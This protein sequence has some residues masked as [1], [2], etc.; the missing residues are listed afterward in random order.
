MG[1]R[2]L[3]LE[4]VAQGPDKAMADLNG[5]V[6]KAASPRGELR[7]R[8]QNTQESEQELRKRE[9]AGE[10][11]TRR[12]AMGGVNICLPALMGQRPMG[13]QSVAREPDKV[14][15]DLDGEA[16]KATPPRGEL[17]LRE[18]DLR[19][20]EQDRREQVQDRR[21]Q[22]QELRE[23]D[24]VEEERGLTVREV[25]SEGSHQKGGEPTRSKEAGQEQDARF[26]AEHREIE[27]QHKGALEA[28]EARHKEGV[29]AF[30]AQLKEELDALRARHKEELEAPERWLKICG[31]W[32]APVAESTPGPWPATRVGV[33][34]EERGGAADKSHTLGQGRGRGSGRG[35]DRDHNHGPSW[36]DASARCGKDGAVSVSKASAASE[37][38][39]VGKAS[40]PSERS[41]AGEASVASEAS[42]AGATGDASEAGEAS[43]TA[44]FWFSGLPPGMPFEGPGRPR[45]RHPETCVQGVWDILGQVYKEPGTSWGV[46]SR[47][48]GLYIGWPLGVIAL[49]CLPYPWRGE[50]G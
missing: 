13:L 29:V 42:E 45:W 6:A 1:R 21:E 2:P 4:S 27:A 38:S 30:G 16:A 23:T 36:A 12:L 34:D 47:R 22:G 15:A 40:V 3:G 24:L 19:E 9:P 46:C 37:P 26:R 7:R 49:V 25:E 39:K 8:E 50:G 41:E 14:K 48:L 11:S 28:F 44:A 10:V 35:D 31:A 18:Q 20:Q 33:K 17:G 43:V 5:K 32:G